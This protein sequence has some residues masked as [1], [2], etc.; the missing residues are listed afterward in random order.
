M[1]QG[2][3]AFCPEDFRLSPCVW[4]ELGDALLLEPATFRVLHTPPAGSEYAGGWFV[5]N[6]T[7]AGGRILMHN[8]SN[9]MWYASIWLAPSRNFAILA[10]ANHGGDGAAKACEE[11]V[12]GLTRLALGQDNGPWRKGAGRG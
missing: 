2:F 12:A 10:A 6:R 11:A 7:W 4:G 1:E 9:T 3:P 8:G 5:A